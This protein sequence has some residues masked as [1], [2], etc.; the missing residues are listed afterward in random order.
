MKL[1]TIISLL[2]SVSLAFAAPPED[3]PLFR[4]EEGGKWGFIDQHGKFVIKPQYDDSYYPF[5][6]G[7][8]AVRIGAKWGY[9]DPSNRMV[10]PAK[11]TGAQNFENG[12]AAVREGSSE[13]GKGRWVYIDKTGKYVFESEEELSYSGFDDGLMY[14]K[15]GE[16]WGY[17][18][19]KGAWAIP[20]KFDDTNNFSDGLA[21]VIAEDGTAGFINTKGEWVI[22]LE[23][24]H[25]HHMG[26]SEGL[27]AVFD[28]KQGAYGYIDKTGNFV[29][30]PRFC[31]VRGF[32]EGR[33]AVC[34][35]EED[36]SGWPLRRW[37]AIDRNGKLI[38]PA[39]YET[40]WSFEEGMAKVVNEDGNGFV[41][42]AGKLA[43]TCKFTTVDPFHNGLAY[44]RVGGYDEK[45]S[46]SG[47][48]D[49]QGEFVWRPKD[50]REK[51]KANLAALQE[52]KSRIPTIRILTK[53]SGDEKGLLV[54]CP[55]KIPFQGKG[56]GEIPISVVNL[57]EEEIFL[58]VPEVQ[59][60]SYSLKHWSGGFS[61]GG[62]SRIIFPDNANLYK[63]M[64]ATSYGKGKKFTCGCCITR[65]NGKLDDDALDAGRAR[66]S[67][68]LR[69][70]GY[71]RN[72]G[73]HFSESIDLPIE[74]IENEQPANPVEKK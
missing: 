66:G 17:L 10:I 39:E 35:I 24:A 5:S 18:D 58:E 74:L 25:P 19:T 16:K 31:E 12:I 71:Y 65:I 53:I 6:E 42:R 60:L 63:R 26:F 11:F 14:E 47:Y 15:K 1:R 3:S 23:N 61:G 46:W 70:E 9:I 43:V 36:A 45:T 28:E 67:V 41:D 22:R 7:L 33:A 48:I 29:I 57:L 56:A 68:T 62:G 64:H 2:L 55:P 54:T 13:V 69:L 30:P 72:S 40:V 8:A 52:E 21:G 4:A 37:G 73:K 49:K 32:T 38:V 34:L 51:D 59:S 50:F 27:A 20:P 44:V